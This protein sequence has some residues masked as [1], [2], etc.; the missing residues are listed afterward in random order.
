MLNPE[1]SR[2]CRLHGGCGRDLADQLSSEHQIRKGGKLVWVKKEKDGS[3][4]H[5]L[6]CLML[7]DA[8]A[9]ATWTPSLPVYVLQLRQAERA[10]NAPA[11]PRRKKEQPRPVERR[12]G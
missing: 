6:D 3:Q 8:C 1:S 11:A 2:P 4:N 12:W 9:D 5:L 7:A 10:A